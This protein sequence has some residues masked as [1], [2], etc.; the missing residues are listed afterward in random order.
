MTQN[1]KMREV[2][3]LVVMKVMRQN[4]LDVLVNPT[5]TIPPARIGFA[6]QPQVNSRPTGR[7]ST[8]ANIGVPEITVPAGFTSV[9]YEPR[10]ALNASKDAYV[11]VANEDTPSTLSHPMPVGMSFWAAPAMKV[12]SSGRRPHTKRRPTAG[13]N[14]RRS[15]RSTRGAR[16]NDAPH[17]CSAATF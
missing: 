13:V 9:V 4:N 10:F 11:T 12:W 15:A 8:S 6:S 3:R 5:T 2:L 16:L 1:V 17:F 14:R 7:F